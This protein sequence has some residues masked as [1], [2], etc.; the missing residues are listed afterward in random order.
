MVLPV[1]R[2]SLLSPPTVS[3]SDGCRRYLFL[4]C[5]QTDSSPEVPMTVFRPS[6]RP[7]PTHPARIPR[8]SRADA[9]SDTA[10]AGPRCPTHSR[11]R[12]PIDLNES[13]ISLNRFSPIGPHDGSSPFSRTTPPPYRSDGPIP[14]GAAAACTGRPA[15]PRAGAHPFE[16]TRNRFQE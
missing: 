15:L 8:A 9:I 12:A 11:G 4:D 1:S 16:R 13:K 2:P 14:T 7:L 6:T 5:F 10:D 3:A